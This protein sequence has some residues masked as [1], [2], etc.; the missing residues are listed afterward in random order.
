VAGTALAQ[1]TSRT[2]P[3]EGVA[4][5]MP[6]PACLL[7]REAIGALAQGDVYWRLTAYPTLQAAER[8][9]PARGTVVAAFGQAWLFTVGARDAPLPGAGGRHVADVGPIPVEAVARAPRTGRAPP[10]G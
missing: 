1:A 3:P 6:G 10:S 4:P 5:D 2:C 8:A 7:K 9:R